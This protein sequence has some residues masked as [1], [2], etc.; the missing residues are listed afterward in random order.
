MAQLSQGSPG[1][2]AGRYGLLHVGTGGLDPAMLQ[3]SAMPRPLALPRLL[4]GASVNG[5][6]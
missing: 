5:L 3:R 4:G 1:G 2:Q 6:A